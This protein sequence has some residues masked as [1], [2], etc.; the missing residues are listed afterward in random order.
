MFICPTRSPSGICHHSLNISKISDLPASLEELDSRLTRAR[1]DMM[2]VNMGTAT[3]SL[4]I[5]HGYVV[6]DLLP[7]RIQLKPLHSGAASFFFE[8]AS[9]L[10]EVS[11]CVVL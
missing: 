6:F 11:S 2:Y 10:H 1:K 5:Y 3:L 8:H 9:R 7:L 4:N